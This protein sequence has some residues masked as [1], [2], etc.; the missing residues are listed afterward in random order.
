MLFHNFS[1]CFSFFCFICLFVCLFFFAAKGDRTQDFYSPS[2]L[3]EKHTCCLHPFAGLVSML[4][5][6]SEVRFSL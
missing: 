6:Q 4:G 1:K 5:L 2:P 3:K